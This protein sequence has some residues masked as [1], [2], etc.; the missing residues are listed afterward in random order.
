[1]TRIIATAALAALLLVLPAQAQ[2]QNPPELAD[3]SPQEN[4]SGGRVRQR[5][6]GNWVRAAIARHSGLITQRVNNPRFGVESEPE[7]ETGAGAGNANAGSAGGT[8]GLGS[9]SSLLELANQFSGSLGSLGSLSELSGLGGL[10]DLLGSLG[11]GGSPST[12]T[13]GGTTNVSIPPPASGSNYTLED[14]LALRDAAGS[15]ANESSAGRQSTLTAG[16]TVSKESTAQTRNGRTFGGAI[17][18]L[19]KP[20][21]RFQ[22]VGDEEP[23]FA[24]RL[25]SSLLQTTFSAL[26]LALQTTDFIEL[27][28]DGLRPLIL[29]PTEEEGADEGAETGGDGASSGNGGQTGSETGGGSDTGGGIE[30]LEPGEENGGDGGS[31]I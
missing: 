16:V 7:P 5:A 19:P 20:E 15:G 27:I 21:Q 2:T 3:L 11:G 14:L 24:S 25:L 17:A 22:A 1:M 29:P 8:S 10:G 13:S 9:L 30:N 26:T 12:T 18:R 31:I 23:K 4:A 28:K 6:P